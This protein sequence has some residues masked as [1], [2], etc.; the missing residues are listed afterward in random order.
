MFFRMMMFVW[1]FML[2]L[3]VVLRMTDD[4]MIWK[5]CSYGTNFASWS[6]NKRG[7]R[8]FHVGRMC[9]WQALAVRVKN[10]A[11]VCVQ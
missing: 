6:G 4:K 2:D 9:R 5:S 1:Q 3:I 8:R 7:D 11:T 10:K